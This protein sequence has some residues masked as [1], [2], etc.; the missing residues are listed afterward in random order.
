ML[1]LQA[2]DAYIDA[3]V[4]ARKKK[5]MHRDVAVD[6]INGDNNMFGVMM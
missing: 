3:L 6:T 2:S 1:I 5:G 4:E